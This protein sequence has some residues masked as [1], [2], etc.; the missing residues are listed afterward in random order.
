MSFALNPAAGDQIGLFDG[1]TWY[2]DTSTSI[3]SFANASQSGGSLK[4]STPFLTGAPVVGDFNGATAP[5]GAPIPDLATYLNG[6]FHIVFGQVNGSGQLFFVADAAHEDTVNMAFAGV[7]GIPVAGNLGDNLP[8]SEYFSDLG[9]YDPA[10]TGVTPQTSQWFWLVADP[11]AN[12]THA[13]NASAL[14]HAFS[15][16]PVGG[17]IFADFGEQTALPIVGNFDPPVTAAVANSPTVNP[18]GNMLGTT[19]VTTGIQTQGWYSFTPLRSG[20]VVVSA[21]GGSGSMS[22]GL[23]DANQNLMA[24]GVPQA[25]GAVT[26]GTQYLV[27]VTGNSA[28]VDLT[29]ADQVPEQT[30]LNVDQQGGITPLDALMIIND[31]NSVGSHSVALTPG[32]PDIYLDANDDGKITPAD[33]LAVINALNAAALAGGS[34]SPAVASFAAAPAS[35]PSGTAAPAIAAAPSSAVNP[36]VVVAPTAVAGSTSANILATD[37]VFASLASGSPPAASTNLQSLSAAATLS[38]NSPAIRKTSNSAGS[39]GADAV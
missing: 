28:A 6:V 36:S 3:T 26:A 20:T 5:N 11:S 24:S 39:N 30:L 7:G 9:V 32:N 31:L 35:S 22:V 27:R 2:L 38:V 14:Q 23:Y 19:S 17:D 10:T 4:F 29:F 18:L 1:T 33:A 13:P 12:P 15:P 21:S 8:G 34:A 25:S 16:A 37:A